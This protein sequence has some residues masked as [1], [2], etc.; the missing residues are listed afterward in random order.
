MISAVRGSSL[1][2][3]STASIFLLLHE[4]EVPR[5]S[6]FNRTHTRMSSTFVSAF[7]VRVHRSIAGLRGALSPWGVATPGMLE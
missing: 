6:L 1:S 4:G 3:A 5:R 2:R 7:P